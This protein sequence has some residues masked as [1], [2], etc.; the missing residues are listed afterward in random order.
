MND[1]ENDHS[2]ERKENLFKMHQGNF[3]STQNYYCAYETPVSITVGG[4]EIL[5]SHRV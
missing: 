3:L 1:I 4:Y 5:L 2:L